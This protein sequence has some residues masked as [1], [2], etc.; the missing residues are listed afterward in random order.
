MTRQR[1]AVMVLV[2]LLLSGCAQDPA[3]SADVGRPGG[4]R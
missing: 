3:H 4:V 2:G 1:R